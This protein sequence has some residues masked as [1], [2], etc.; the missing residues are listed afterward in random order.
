[1]TQDIQELINNMQGFELQYET[2]KGYATPHF[3][4]TD[5]DKLVQRLDR[6]RRRHIE[7]TVLD[8]QTREV[9][10]GV[11]PGDA[12]N[13]WNYWLWSKPEPELELAKAAIAREGALCQ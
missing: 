12:V 5:V 13:P 11:T 9:V 10:G 3:R 1:M 4:R 7:A 2:P 6:L 8:M